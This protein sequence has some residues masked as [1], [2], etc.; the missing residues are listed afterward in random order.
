MKQDP[1]SS[2]PLP[3]GEPKGW[4]CIRPVRIYLLSEMAIISYR[5]QQQQPVDR[6]KKGG[7]KSS[8]RLNAELGALGT[9]YQVVAICKRNFETTNIPHCPH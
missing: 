7:D 3:L 5:Q 1:I 4:M 9:T 6:S 2:L 8:L